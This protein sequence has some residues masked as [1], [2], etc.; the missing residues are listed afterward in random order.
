MA[1]QNRA[2]A[3]DLPALQESVL[4]SRAGAKG[5]SG[6]DGG[7]LT[8]DRATLEDNRRAQGQPAP[9]PT[10]SAGAFVRLWE[11]RVCR[12]TLG[13]VRD[14]VAMIRTGKEMI[15]AMPGSRRL[16]R[17]CGEWSVFEGHP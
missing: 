10:G 14:G 7:Q 11:C 2:T 9:Q 8:R 3:D 15:D 4:G 5:G 17:R 6:R 16:C 13:K 12:A 1:A